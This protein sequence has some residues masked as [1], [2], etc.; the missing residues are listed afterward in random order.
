MRFSSNYCRRTQSLSPRYNFA[1]TLLKH[2]NQLCAGQLLANK[3]PEKHWVVTHVSLTW[4]GPTLKLRGEISARFHLVRRGD[5]CLSARDGRHRFLELQ[6][7]RS[8]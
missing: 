1:F 5:D 6:A 2:Y 7:N 4:D 3:S 8:V